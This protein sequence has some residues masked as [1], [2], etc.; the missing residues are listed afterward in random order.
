M[1]RLGGPL[2]GELEV[3]DEG[4]VVSSKSQRKSDIATGREQSTE[5]QELFPVQEE[6]EDEADEELIYLVRSL[7]F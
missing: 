2:A 1:L 3:D 5:K 7:S 4:A 6:E